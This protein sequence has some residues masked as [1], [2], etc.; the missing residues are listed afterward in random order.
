MVR[1]LIGVILLLPTFVWAFQNE[2]S[3]F[4]GHEWGTPYESMAK[5]LELVED[6]DVKIYSKPGDKL[7][8]GNAELSALVYGFYDNKLALVMMR[9]KGSTNGQALLKAFE[10]EFGYSNNPNI[11]SERYMWFGLITGIVLS[12]NSDMSQCTG[13]LHSVELTGAKL[14]ADVEKAKQAH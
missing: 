6:S 8:F 5:T 14:K 11:Q 13:L 2:P 1:L 12:C 9:S 10:T 7:T 4:R 3:G